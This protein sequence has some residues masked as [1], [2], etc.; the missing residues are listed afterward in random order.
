MNRNELSRL[1]I[2]EL[3]A[4]FA[5]LNF[6]GKNSVFAMHWPGGVRILYA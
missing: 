1:R 3:R 5:Q 6:V 2:D 4:D